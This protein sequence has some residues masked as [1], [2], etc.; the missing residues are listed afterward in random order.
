MEG[1]STANARRQ[2]G[3][4]AQRTLQAYASTLRT[5][6]VLV[7]EPNGHARS[8]A[9]VWW[10]NTRY[11]NEPEGALGYNKLVRCSFAWR[12]VWRGGAALLPGML[13]IEQV[14]VFCAGC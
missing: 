1:G 7:Y 13:R 5:P 12:G 9:P 8:S 2:C 6:V 14:V 3:S 11:M 4:G 10:R